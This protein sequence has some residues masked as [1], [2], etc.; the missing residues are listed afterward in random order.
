MSPKTFA[1]IYG[2]TALM[3]AV[4]AMHLSR[5]KTEKTNRKLFKLIQD[6]L[7]VSEMDFEFEFVQAS[8]TREPNNIG[9][10]KALQKRNKDGWTFVTLVEREGPL[11]AECGHTLVFSRPKN[12]NVTA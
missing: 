9:L 8:S 3:F 1:K 4:I 6:H 12:K 5:R 10:K 7:T 11:K 2:A